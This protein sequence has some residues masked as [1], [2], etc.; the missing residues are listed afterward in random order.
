MLEK[1]LI[2]TLDHGHYAGT[3]DDEYGNEDSVLTWKA[4][5]PG[6]YVPAC[7]PTIEHPEGGHV[8]RLS[9]SLGEDE[10]FC[11]KIGERKEIEIEDPMM[12][13]RIEMIWMELADFIEKH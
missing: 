9:I 7:V 12:M 6:H 13:G 10:L 3:T 5:K 4:Y 1:V 11:W 8:S 2:T